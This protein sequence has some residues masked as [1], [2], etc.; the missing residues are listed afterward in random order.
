MALYFVIYLCRIM[1][2]SSLLSSSFFHPAHLYLF[3]RSC[4]DSSESAQKMF[5]QQIL[6]SCWTDITMKI[7]SFT[8]RQKK[9]HFRVRGMA[10]S[11]AHPEGLIDHIR[12]SLYLIAYPGQAGGRASRRAGTQH[13]ESGF[14]VQTH[15]THRLYY[16]GRQELLHSLPQPVCLTTPSVY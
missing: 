5:E 14:L 15:H 11:W 12:L 2:Y 9:N 6:M 1:L 16:W 7:S 4:P 10:V 3:Q 8:W 13:Q